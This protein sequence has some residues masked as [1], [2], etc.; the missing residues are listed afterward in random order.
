MNETQ[1]TRGQ[2]AT[3]RGI[4]DVALP[5]GGIAWCEYAASD[6]VMARQFFE[7]LFGWT[8]RTKEFGVDAAYT[9]FMIEDGDRRHDVAGLLSLS[10]LACAPT[11]GSWLPVVPVDDVDRITAKAADLGALVLSQPVGFPGLGRH[12]TIA[13]PSGIRCSLVDVRHDVV[14][15]GPGCV[16]WVEIRAH[17]P[18]KTAL[19]AW[20]AF[21]WQAE[22]VRDHDWSIRSVFLHHGQRVLSMRKADPGEP[23]RCLPCI[24]CEDLDRTLLRALELGAS[25]RE[26]RDDDPIHGRC[27]RLAD[28]LGE[29][30]MLVS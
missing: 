23:S 22:S 28:P 5:P 6:V 21:G 25:V 27:V 20:Q 29:E 1:T 14:S 19:F 9:T 11:R 16:R 17:D 15:R 26:R 12:A 18:A 13:G 2:Q 7:R 4:R 10:D 24:E 8:S 3:S 30:F